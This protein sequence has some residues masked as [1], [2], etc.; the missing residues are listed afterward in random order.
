[1]NE[2]KLII[3]NN[4]IYI[5][6]VYCSS[7][8]E[9][10]KILENIARKKNLIQFIRKY[11]DDA[12]YNDYLRGISELQ[13]QNYK[14]SMDV[15]SALFYLFNK[16][17]YYTP[18]G[19]TILYRGVNIECKEAINDKG[20]MSTSS[21]IDVAQEFGNNIMEIYLLNTYNY[22][23][24]PIES[25]TSVKNEYEVI[26]APGRGKFYKCGKSYKINK[27]SE[28]Y[29]VTKYVYVPKEATNI[30]FITGDTQLNNISLNLYLDKFSQDEP[31]QIIK[32]DGLITNV[33]KKLNKVVPIKSY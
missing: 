29:K 11:T 25:I 26:L 3:K 10:S 22:K 33:L 8:D 21:E 18:I 5:G 14:D 13:E 28:V 27:N 2:K 30:P 1:M 31:M 23:L 32:Y 16:I 4:N 7:I 9:Q 15:I 12:Y 17:P 6:G 19:Y 20:F 24:L